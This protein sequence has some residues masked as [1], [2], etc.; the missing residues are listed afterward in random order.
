MTTTVEFFKEYL[1]LKQN[2]IDFWPLW[3][4][5]ENLLRDM[6]IKVLLSK[7]GEEWERGFLLDYP[8]REKQ[9]DELK[10]VFDKN[11]KKFEERAKTHLVY[12]TNPRELYDIFIS[13][14]WSSF[15]NILKD[16]SKKEWEKILIFLADV[17]NPI[18]HNNEYHLSN[19][20]KNIAI[21]YCEIIKNT[22]K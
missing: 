8:K 12:Y 19:H 13:S 1:S 14:D 9:I 15:Q 7:Y 4:E 5:V 22:L 10:V 16:K 17:R 21:S 2:E 11:K 6:I 3:N 18:A 20:D